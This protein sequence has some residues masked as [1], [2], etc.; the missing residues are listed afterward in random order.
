MTTTATNIEQQELPA[1]WK[2]VKLGDVSN[3]SSG[4]TPSRNIPEYWNGDIPWAKI[5]DISAT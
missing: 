4:S 5:Q 2:W 1:G 3:A